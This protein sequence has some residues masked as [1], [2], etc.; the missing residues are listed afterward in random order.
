MVPC[1]SLRFHNKSS[2]TILLFTNVV[3]D[4]LR[5]VLSRNRSCLLFA[6]HRAR[7]WPRPCIVVLDMFGVLLVRLH[8][9]SSLR[10]QVQLISQI[11]FVNCGCE[12]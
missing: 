10:S 9:L 2:H 8:L 3:T 12:L 5:L 4:A 11:K 1:A 6:S 7:S